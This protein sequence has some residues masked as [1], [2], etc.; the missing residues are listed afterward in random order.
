ML[1]SLW[2]SAYSDLKFLPAYDRWLWST[3]WITMGRRK[4]KCLQRRCPSASF[5]IA[6]ATW[7]IASGPLLWTVYE[8][9]STKTVSKTTK[10]I[11]LKIS[12]WYVV[13]WKVQKPSS[14]IVRVFFLRSFLTVYKKVSA[15]SALWLSAKWLYFTRIFHL[16]SFFV[17]RNKLQFLAV[18]YIGLN[19]VI[20]TGVFSVKFEPTF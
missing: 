20:E 9:L 3:A 4:P 8:L 16:N 5:F 17:L 19:F 13:E 1:I 15:F 2:D 7:T 10:K 14:L 18:K 11:S 12:G 6:F